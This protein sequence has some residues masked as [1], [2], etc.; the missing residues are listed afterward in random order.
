M[1]FRN[2]PKAGSKIMRMIMMELTYGDGKRIE[3]LMD[4]Y[5][6]KLLLSIEEL[7]QKIG[8]LEKRLA[9]LENGR[10]VTKQ[11]PV[12]NGV[13]HKTQNIGKGFNENLSPM[14]D[15]SENSI[16]NRS[17]DYR[18]DNKD[19]SINV[20]IGDINKTQKPGSENSANSQKNERTGSLKP[21]DISIE[22]YF[23][24]GKKS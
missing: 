4:R 13:N 3:M 18:D 8:A 10:E 1:P 17:S 23:Y 15:F 5:F 24:A 16:P 20:K 6:K 14:S 21:G 11:N 19:E 12:N 7:N 22:K 9:G 2:S